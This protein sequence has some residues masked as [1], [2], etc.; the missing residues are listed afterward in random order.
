MVASNPPGNFLDMTRVS[1]TT[2]DVPE[3][4]SSAPGASLVASAA[5]TLQTHES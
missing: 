4:S 1:S 3:P 5:S 2:A